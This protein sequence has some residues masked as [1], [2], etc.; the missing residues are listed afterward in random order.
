MYIPSGPSSAVEFN[1]PRIKTLDRHYLLLDAN[2]WTVTLVCHK[3]NLRLQLTLTPSSY[4]IGPKTAQMLARRP[5]DMPM[6]LNLRV[7]PTRHPLNRLCVNVP[8]MTLKWFWK[9]WS[10]LHVYS[11]LAAQVNMIHGILDI[12]RQ[13][14]TIL[15]IHELSLVRP[16]RKPLRCP[17]HPWQWLKT[18]NRSSIPHHRPLLNQSHILTKGPGSSLPCL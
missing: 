7:L 14:T 17:P 2:R 18:W 4:H 16:R 3:P 1:Q 9:D 5:Q 15:K 6:I 8:K 10:L 12:F 11:I 13:K